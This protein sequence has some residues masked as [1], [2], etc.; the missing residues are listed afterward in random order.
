MSDK[1][2]RETFPRLL[3]DCELESVIRL[4]WF[5]EYPLDHSVYALYGDEFVE[6]IEH[7]IRKSFPEHAG[8]AKMLAGLVWMNP[9]V[10]NHQKRMSSSWTGAFKR[11]LIPRGEFK[12]RWDSESDA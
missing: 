1:S 2:E 9:L 3:N 7:W 8:D 12:H 11:L 10:I 4:R 6:T 5:K